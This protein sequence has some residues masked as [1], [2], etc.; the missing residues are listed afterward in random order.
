MNSYKRMAAILFLALS[1]HNSAVRATT[2]SEYAKQIFSFVTQSEDAKAKLCRFGLTIGGLATA[3]YVWNEIKLPSKVAGFSNSFAHR[4]PRTAAA[5]KYTGQALGFYSVLKIARPDKTTSE[6]TFE[7]ANAVAGGVM[8]GVAGYLGQRTAERVLAQADNNNQVEDNKI[9]FADIAGGVPAAVRN[10]VDDVQRADELAEFGLA[11]AKGF[12]FY[13]PP[14]TGKTLLA[15][16][17]AGEIPSCGFFY[18]DGSSFVNKYVGT[19]PAAIQALFAQAE[20]SIR[21]GR[22]KYAL[23]FID[24]ID[25]V[26]KRSGAD[27]GG[28]AMK[29]YNNTINTLL[30][31]LDGVGSCPGIFVIGAT[32][33]LKLMDEAITRSGRLGTHIEIPLPDEA[34]RAALFEHYLGTKFPRI[35]KAEDINVAQLAS[36]TAGA[37]AADIAGIVA[38]AAGQAVRS[39][40]DRQ[41]APVITHE[42]LERCLPS[43]AATS[44]SEIDYMGDLS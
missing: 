9:T 16:A 38:S 6:Q 43:Q 1:L 37:C 14:G 42:M 34:K 18:A 28:A 12:L 31:C 44:S 21:S 23:I 39:R 24:E 26:G 15:Q 32:N 33:R 19:G 5:V 17:V 3:L 20:N 11:P 36:R 30:T 27:S 10:L 7:L 8:K 41:Q 4:F 13:G 22:N 40:V 35:T 25:G 29:E 2:F